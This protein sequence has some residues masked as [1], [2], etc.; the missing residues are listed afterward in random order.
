MRT[1]RHTGHSWSAVAWVTVALAATLLT[2]CY[3]F[4]QPSFHPAEGRDVLVAIARR[5][6][7]VHSA[8]AG[9]SACEDRGLIGNA[10]RLE[11]SL[12][13][14]AA[15]RDLFLYTFRARSWE[16]S[17]AQVDACQ[18][19]YAAA[20]PGARIGRLD[21]PTLRALGADWSM[22][23]ETLLREALIE[24]STQPGAVVERGT[25]SVLIASVPSLVASTAR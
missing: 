9:T 1:P 11:V 3:S 24:A 6:I 13:S 14:D 8:V 17:Q 22:E 18:A 4:A 2:G 23:L 16:S 20:N 5:G 19:E 7:T 21:V 10:V 12:P 25:D 15:P